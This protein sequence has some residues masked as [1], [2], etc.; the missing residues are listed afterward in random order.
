MHENRQGL[1]HKQLHACVHMGRKM[2]FSEAWR[3]DFFS[4]S[5]L[6][7]FFFSLAFGSKWSLITLVLASITA[8]ANTITPPPTH[9]PPS[10]LNTSCSNILP[11][12]CLITGWLQCWLYCLPLS[13]P[14]A[15]VVAVATFLD[16]FQKVADLATNSRGR[17]TLKCAVSWWLSGGLRRRQRLTNLRP[18]AW[19]SHSPCL[20]LQFGREWVEILRA[21]FRRFTSSKQETRSATISNVLQLVITITK[22]FLKQ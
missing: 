9:T 8:T 12:C 21:Q 1:W 5:S 22:I 2:F 14:R 13:S 20:L 6:P 17:N 4:F 10:F 11:W 3:T 15:T 16:A 19:H 18:N 7:S